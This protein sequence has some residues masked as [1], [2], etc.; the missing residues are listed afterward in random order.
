MAL[1]RP[2]SPPASSTRDSLLM[3]GGKNLDFTDKVVRMMFS[4]ILYSFHL[5]ENA[6]TVK[7]ITIPEM[8]CT[9]RK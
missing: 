3:I 6:R 9:F 7:F 4:I 2:V 1:S 5:L 8:C